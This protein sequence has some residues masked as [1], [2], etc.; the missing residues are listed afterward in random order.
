MNPILPGVDPTALPAPVWLFE[1]L[2][3]VT[4]V[5]HLFAMNLLLGGGI[6]AIVSGLR[7]RSGAPHHRQL[8]GKIARILPVVMAMTVTL[9]V[10]PLLFVQVLYG[11]FFYTSSILLAVP[12]FAV[13][14]L[15]VLAYYG[16]YFVSFSDTVR[17]ERF[18]WVGWL[19][20]LFVLL[21]GFIYTNNF[22]LMQS[23]ERF[24]DLYVSGRAGLRLN[25]AEPTLIP[26]FLHFV[27]AAVAVAGLAIA[28][29]GQQARRSG[30]KGFGSWCTRYG[31]TW[32][33]GGTLVQI[34]IGFWFLFTLPVAIRNEFLGNN[35]VY[36]AHLFTAVFLALVAVFLLVA[37]AR[38][39][40]GFT[41][42]SVLLIIAVAVMVLVRSWV[43]DLEIGGV[44]RLEAASVDTQWSVLI[45]FL[46]L[47]I[48]GIITVGWM[49]R[50]YVAEG[51]H[52]P[53]VSE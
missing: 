46:A 34:L 6:V 12:W 9:G 17:R 14:G 23:P 41:L 36:T 13:V 24:Y 26:R 11:R 47:F 2:R 39:R 28:G 32:F 4:F 40:T 37:A 8:A 1:L 7:G 45:L 50:R 43:R 20:G 48:G 15:L 25:L 52:H 5:L 10:A 3:M 49:I 22:T 19:S 21:V 35:V 27:V 18:L 16:H 30:E 31:M 51:A 44:A 38:S 33:A 29:I 53:E 42:S